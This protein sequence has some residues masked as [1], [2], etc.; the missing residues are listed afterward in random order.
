MIT[1]SYID[2]D[3]AS[4]FSSSR[5]FIG[6]R[7]VLVLCCLLCAVCGLWVCWA[8][9]EFLLFSFSF[10]NEVIS[11]VV[12]SLG[13]ILVFLLKNLYLTNEQHNAQP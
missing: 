5:R 3:V 4:F 13:N 1:E 2:D 9:G 12:I 7:R 10:W 11:V 6:V 8:E